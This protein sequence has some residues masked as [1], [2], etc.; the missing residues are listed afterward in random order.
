MVGGM[1]TILYSKSADA[2]R[3][4]FRDVLKFP[5]VDAGHGWLLFAT[6]PA[7]IAVHPTEGRSYAELYL[8][9]RNIHDT[10]NELKKR[11]VEFT[12]EVTEQRWGLLTHL[13]LPDGELLGLYEPR[14]PLS[15]RME[16]I[17]TGVTRKSSAKKKSSRKKKTRA[18]T[19]VRKT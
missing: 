10:I 14:H 13:R 7:E 15:I 3:V 19:G 9:C 6:P 5:C 11:G 4:F 16:P 12:S 2:V 1:H 18:Q 8:M 17:T